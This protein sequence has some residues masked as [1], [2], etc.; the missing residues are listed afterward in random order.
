MP[1][2]RVLADW[3]SQ[4]G[5]A[6]FDFQKQ[7]WQA[8]ARGQSGLIHA[9]TGMGKT[10]AIWLGLLARCG[11]H[12]PPGRLRILWITPLPGC[13]GGF[14]GKPASVRV[15]RM[16][17]HQL[18]PALLADPGPSTLRSVWQ[19]AAIE[20]RIFRAVDRYRP[21]RDF[22]GTIDFLRTE[23]HRYPEASD[24]TR[25]WGS[26]ATGGATV[27]QVPGD[28]DTWLTQHA[29]RFGEVLDELLAAGA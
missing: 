20:F 4:N 13:A 17:R 22:R 24:A 28:H 12:S 10:L 2:S 6:P 27:R 25:G 14:F 1:I 26:V 8:C 3:F 5:W 11:F 21:R 19:H 18:A 23:R 16:F 7:T 29:A 15:A 9:A